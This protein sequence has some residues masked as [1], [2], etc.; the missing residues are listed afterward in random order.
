MT[1]SI[2]TIYGPVQARKGV[3]VAPVRQYPMSKH[4][5]PRT[6]AFL[7]L[8]LLVQLPYVQVHNNTT[9]ALNKHQHRRCHTPGPHS[10]AWRCRDRGRRVPHFPQIRHLEGLLCSP[11]SA[12][13][14]S[15]YKLFSP[16][17]LVDLSSAKLQRSSFS[18]FLFSATKREPTRL[19]PSLPPSVP[20]PVPLFPPSLDRYVPSP[21]RLQ[22][23]WWSP[24]RARRCCC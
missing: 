11:H 21:K 17:L 3:P 12:P 7:L 4:W 15:W 18:V 23:L 16:G 5:F 9:I 1:I 24:H 2:R 19:S 8:L 20:T 6:S 22:C 14:A 13:P 10:R